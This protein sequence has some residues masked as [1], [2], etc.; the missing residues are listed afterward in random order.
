MTNQYK[1]FDIAERQ[2]EEAMRQLD[3]ARSQLRSEKQKLIDAKEAPYREWR[4]LPNM[5]GLTFRRQADLDAFSSLMGDPFIAEFASFIVDCFSWPNRWIHGILVQK[6][7]HDHEIPFWEFDWM[8][9]P[10]WSSYATCQ[11]AQRKGEWVVYVADEDRI[12]MPSHWN[13]HRV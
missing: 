1:S 12:S 5:N 13:V 8:S 9:L 7:E 3:E 2:L 6:F 11:I 4:A 10:S